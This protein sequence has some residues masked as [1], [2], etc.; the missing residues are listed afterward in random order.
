M[1]GINLF[2]FSIMPNSF[3]S[4]LFSPKILSFFKKF[5]T[6]K[7]KSGLFLSSIDIKSPITYLFFIFLSI[8]KSSAKF[9]SKWYATK[10]TFSYFLIIFYIISK[11]KI[12]NWLKYLKITKKM[13]NKYLHLISS[14]LS[15][16]RL[17][18]PR[19]V[20]NPCGFLILRIFV[21]IPLL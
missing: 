2:N 6:M 9:K 17:L 18:F 8:C 4:F 1:Q 20:L 15:L 16:I 11:F 12:S 5:K 14:H 13:P 19:I 7:S 21:W 10:R 3:I